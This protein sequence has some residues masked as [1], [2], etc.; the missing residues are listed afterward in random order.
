MVIPLRGLIVISRRLMHF[1]NG[2]CMLMCGTNKFRWR[3]H[4]FL[5]DFFATGFWTKSIYFD[6]KSDTSMII[7]VGGCGSMEIA[8]HLLFSCDTF[9]N[10]WLA[11]LPWLR[12]SFV[13]PAGCRN[14]FLQFGQLAGFPRS[15]YTFLRIIWMACVWIIWKER[16]NRFFHQM[17]T[18]PHTLAEKVKLLSFR[19]LKAKP[20]TFVFRYHD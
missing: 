7:C 6:D 11:V 4:C 12:L 9:G 1:L 5:G 19:W 14:H 13:A 8:D 15:S 16:N 18:A 10:V 3:Y 20:S 2:A 17:A